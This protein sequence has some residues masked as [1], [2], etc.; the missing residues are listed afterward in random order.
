MLE[1]GVLT[2]ISVSGNTDIETPA[3]F[4]VGESAANIEN[5]YGASAHVEPHQYWQP[6]A[7]YITVWRDASSDRERRGIRYEIDSDGNVVHLR[8]GGPSIEYVE[9]C[10]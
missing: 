1:R 10:V 9:G 2:R 5:L 6:P 8:A 4:A 7:R 3:G